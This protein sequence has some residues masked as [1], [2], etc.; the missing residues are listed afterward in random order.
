MSMTEAEGRDCVFGR[1]GVHIDFA[2]EIWCFNNSLKF[3]Y[4]NLYSFAKRRMFKDAQLV[5]EER[6]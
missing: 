5:T 3:R 2:T 4:F 1:Q 6:L